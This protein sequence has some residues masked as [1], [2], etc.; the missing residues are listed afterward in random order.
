MGILPM[1]EIEQELGEPQQVRDWRC[2]NYWL[3]KGLIF[4]QNNLL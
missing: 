2:S 3:A 1:Y 4:T